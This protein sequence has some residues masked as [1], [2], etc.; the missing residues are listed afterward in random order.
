MTLIGDI[1]AFFASTPTSRN[2][3]SSKIVELCTAGVASNSLRTLLLRT[4]Q[5]DPTLPPT[6]AALAAGAK[7]LLVDKYTK[8]NPDL[9]LSEP[10]VQGFT[11]V[12]LSAD[13]LSVEF[14]G[15]QE[16]HVTKDLGD[17]PDAGL[18]H[19]DRVEVKAGEKAIYREVEGEFR[20]W[21]AE[22]WE[23]V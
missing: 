18:F 15:I 13:K 5:G 23:Y 7:N 19:I 9:A 8:P 21:D 12:N 2:D 1:H 17:N 3:G 4:A 20:R 16:E 22:A 10:E 11:I 14:H 6:A